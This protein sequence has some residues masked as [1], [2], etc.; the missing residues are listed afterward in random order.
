MSDFF[1]KD[2][3]LSSPN[4]LYEMGEAYW[5]GEKVPRDLPKAARMWH[6]AAKQDYP[7]A[8]HRLARAYLKAEGVW[9]TLDREKRL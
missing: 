2:P 1:L 9:S 3:K 5:L 8:H 7:G 6:L 4:E